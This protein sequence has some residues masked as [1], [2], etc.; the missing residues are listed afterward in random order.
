MTA[1]TLVVANDRLAD[2]AS[3]WDT[4]GFV[5]ATCNKSPVLVDPICAI[6]FF[7]C[8]NHY[9]LCDDGFVNELINTCMHLL[10]YVVWRQ[11]VTGLGIFLGVAGYYPSLLVVCW[12]LFLFKWFWSKYETAST[13]TCGYYLK[14]YWLPFEK[15][16]RKIRKVLAVGISVFWIESNNEISI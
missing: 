9:H 6:R 5:G 1:T 3:S 15:W 2:E 16:G 8:F 13:E 7:N 10:V 12:I 14:G 11:Q 4:S